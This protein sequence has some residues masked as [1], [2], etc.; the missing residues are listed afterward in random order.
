MTTRRPIGVLGGGGGWGSH[1]E[2]SLL[3]IVINP[4]YGDLM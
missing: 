2:S 1:M 3:P 4:T